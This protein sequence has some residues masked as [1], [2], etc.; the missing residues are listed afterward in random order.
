MLF[1]LRAHISMLIRSVTAPARG[2][3]A[4]IACYMDV[5]Q[6]N[7]RSL[8]TAFTRAD[9]AVCS[10]NSYIVVFMNEVATNLVI[11]IPTPQC[12]V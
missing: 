9:I 2:T 12:T 1:E 3:N 7:R 4:S 10:F 11:A 8:K 6:W 5:Q